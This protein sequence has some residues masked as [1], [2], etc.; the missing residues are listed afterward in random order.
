MAVVVMM[1]GVLH[2]VVINQDKSV[3]LYVLR[4]MIA[5]RL[6]LL[7]Q[8]TTNMIVTHFPEVEIISTPNVELQIQMNCVLKNQVSMLL[9]VNKV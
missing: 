6:I 5:L 2:T 9:I 1:A 4:T 7:V 8:M 3:W